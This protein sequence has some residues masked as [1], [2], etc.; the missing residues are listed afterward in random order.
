M[1]DSHVVVDDLSKF[2][3]T[4]HHLTHTRPL[5]FFGVYDGHGGPEAAVFV[6][7]HMLQQLVQQLRQGPRSL[8]EVLARTFLRTD[9][10]LADSC[11]GEK[12]DIGTTAIVS[13]VMGRLLLVANAGDCRAVLCHRGKAVALSRDHTPKCEDEKRRIKAA[14]GYVEGGYLNGVISVSRGFG[15]FRLKCRQ[16]AHGETGP[17]TAIPEIT[18]HYLQPGDEFMVLG[19]D[20]LW[21]VM[22]S[23]AVISYARRILRACGDPE[24]CARELVK[25][26]LRL[27]STD[28][29]SVVVISFAPVEPHPQR[30]SSPVIIGRVTGVAR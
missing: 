11:A 28:N 8:S 3:E 14:G 25:E 17:L 5:A 12:E 18:E 29:V 7:Q 6:Q 2:L 9:A 21:D 15:D 1:E 22:P 30:G 27:H 20:G 23:Q 10:A 26:A 13:L 16:G 24:A 4:E 19:C